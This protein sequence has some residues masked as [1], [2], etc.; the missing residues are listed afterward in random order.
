L[1]TLG[2]AASAR[3]QHTGIILSYSVFPLALLL[4]QLALERR[5]HLLALAFSVTAV[6][7]AVGRNQVA[8]LLCALLAAAAVA[9]IAGS[10]QRARYVRERGSLL[11][12][13]VVAGAALLI[14]P[15]LLT[16]QFAALSNRPTEVLGDALRGSLYP[17]N[18]A[19]VAIADIFGTHSAYWGPGA[20]TL[21]EVDLTDDSENYLFVGAVPTLLLL[22]FG[23]AGRRA[24]LPGCRLMACALAVSC[25]FML[26]RYTPFYGLAFRF[27]PGVDLFRRPTD[28]SFVF[29]IAT[30]FVVGHCLADYVADG[31]PRLRPLGALVA[32]S[33]SVAAVGSAIAFSARTG[34]ALEAAREALISLAVM[35]ATGLFVVA[36]RRERARARVAAVVAL[37]AVA[38]LLW[39]NT[40]FRLNA[41]PWKAYAVLEAPAGAEA[42]AI[43]LLENSIAA[44][45]RRGDYPRVEV[46][47]LGGAWQNLAMVRGWEAIN[48]Y[49]PLRIGLYDRLVAPGEQNWNVSQREF[50]STFNSYDSPL[51]KAL[52]LTYLVLGSPLQRL[53][54]LSSLPPCELLL[55]GPP[56]WIYRLP[57]ALPRVSMISEPGTEATHADQSPSV[58]AGQGGPSGDL[59]PD[60]G[61]SP[62][63]ARIESA[64]PGRLAVVTTSRAS[65]LLLVHDL[66]YPGWVAEVDGR[67]RPVLRADPLF[68]AVRIPAGVHHVTFRFAPFSPANLKSALTAAV[69]EGTT[70]SLR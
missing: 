31:L 57:G 65:E 63:V 14:V 64:V 59:Q 38:E 11:T 25:L 10:K 8:L 37:A 27:V 34:H 36:L 40:A 55:S 58:P 62:G 45:H 61:A 12:V 42:A 56:I 22:W 69:G 17:A 9:E 19:N 68:R 52:G 15:L 35:L 30:A 16:M 70:A 13:M 18:F 39:W 7:M 41:E 24:W 28:A 66:Y 6:D 51:A 48:G 50:P 54:G 23:V 67:Q 33:V 2:G 4:L 3:L 26:G 60:V 46:L 47:G 49:N 21:A 5:S 44:D 20:K 53:P 43:A 1:F 29:G 32:L